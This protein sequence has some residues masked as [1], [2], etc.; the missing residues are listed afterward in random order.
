MDFAADESLAVHLLSNNR[1]DTIVMA[2][3]LADRRG[4]DALRNLRRL[5]RRPLP[6]LMLGAPGAAPP[7]LGDGLGPDD[8]LV[9]PYSLDAITG[10][11]G[12]LRRRKGK[13][14]ARLQVGDLVFDVN[15]HSVHRQG[16]VVVVD[17]AL[18]PVLQ[19]LMEASPKRVSFRELG[20][21]LLDEQAPVA[22]ARVRVRMRALREAVD[23]PFQSPMIRNRRDG[24]C[25]LPPDV[26][27][28]S[29]EKPSSRRP[30]TRR[31]LPA[32]HAL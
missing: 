11:L 19:A 20:S 22:D 28:L 5:M 21:C 12:I 2:E 4:F 8:Y 25:I 14:R 10:R 3:R 26:S 9:P 6:V 16:H 1:F 29:Q 24:F 30:A 23:M 31:V 18:L 17:E 27:P 13:C 32:V 7:V 15:N